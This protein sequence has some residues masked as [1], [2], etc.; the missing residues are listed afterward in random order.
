MVSNFRLAVDYGTSFT[1]A[2]VADGS[3]LEVL[4]FTGARNSRYLPS[5]VLVDQRGELHVGTR[6]LS[7]RAA[8]PAE[9]VCVAPKR[10][11]GPDGLRL[12]SRELSAADV[13]A[14]T[15]GK[16]AEE[17]RH[18]NNG[19]PPDELVM[20]YPAAWSDARCDVLR[21]A[22]ASAGLVSDP[23]SVV[24]VPEPVAAVRFHAPSRGGAETPVG[25]A[26]AV[27]DLGGGTFD[28]AVLR[29]TDSGWVLAGPPGGDE[30]LGGEDFDEAL[31]D[32][33]ADRVNAEDPDR[34]DEFEDDDSPRGRSD[35]VTLLELIRSAKEDLSSEES[36]E[37]GLPPGALPLDALLIHRS[38]FATLIAQAI[39]RSMDAFAR[40]LDAASVA[41]GDLTAT[42]LTGGS[43]RIPLIKG[44]MHRRFGLEPIT[45]KDPKSIT[46]LG[47]LAPDAPSAPHAET[48]E[49]GQSASI[50]SG[51]RPGPSPTPAV[52][53]QGATLMRATCPDI[54]YLS[55]MLEAVGAFADPGSLGEHYRGVGIE[56][57]GSGCGLVAG[58]PKRGAIVTVPTSG[59]DAIMTAQTLFFDPT[60][61]TEWARG[62][63]GPV[64]VAGTENSLTLS[65]GSGAPPLEVVV[66]AAKYT[67]MPAW[68]N[69]GNAD[70]VAELNLPATGVD[71]LEAAVRQ[72]S[73]ETIHVVCSPTAVVFDGFAPPGELQ[74]GEPTELHVPRHPIASAL[75][76]FRGHSVSVGFQR[77]CMLLFTDDDDFLQCCLWDVGASRTP[78]GSPPGTGAAQAEDVA[79]VRITPKAV[80]GGVGSMG[81]RFHLKIDGVEHPTDGWKPVT[82]DLRPGRHE[83]ECYNTSATQTYSRAKTTIDVFAGQ[84]LNLRFQQG[85]TTFNKGKLVLE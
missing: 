29:R 80:L 64:T 42:Y 85:I 71:V 7:K 70:P 21:A 81:V 23:S 72:G 34:W 45:Y 44:E 60:A 57:D 10:Q 8:V 83:I 75:T 25:G 1:A 41:P 30:R 52:T 12:G 61:A 53:P 58:T 5:L 17:A 16:V 40:C 32:W 33:V 76:A 15:L 47:A 79:T 77:H 22:A 35:W 78:G 20:T 24:M 2:A 55:S 13:V 51:S 4:E 11:L 68:G 66:A 84:R 39:D 6:A 56:V 59:D 28:C 14:A 43:S 36:T 65:Q 31:L 74:F 9:N 26:V 46:S 69:P 49:S 19:L 62:R 50:P 48:R 67:T 82:F 63:S 73:G 27:Y 3:G 18:R 38:E 37:I 54:A